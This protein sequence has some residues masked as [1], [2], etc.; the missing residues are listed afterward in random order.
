M[1]PFSARWW[2]AACPAASSTCPDVNVA[3]QCMHGIL[4]QASVWLRPGADGRSRAQVRAAVV[5]CA[6]R[7]FV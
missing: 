7:L 5:D 6:L 2:S 3:L 4:N 1:T